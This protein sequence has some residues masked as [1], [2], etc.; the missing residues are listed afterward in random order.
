MGKSWL[1]LWPC[2]IVMLVCQR[3]SELTFWLYNIAMENDPFMDDDDKH[4]DLPFLR[5]VIFHSYVKD[6]RVFFPGEVNIDVE[7]SIVSLGTCSTCM[8]GFP[9]LYLVGGLEHFLFF[10]ILRTIIPTDELIFFRGVGQPPT[11]SLLEGHKCNDL[12]VTSTVVSRASQLLANVGLPHEL[13]RGRSC[14]FGCDRTCFCWINLF[15][16]LLNLIILSSD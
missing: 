11:I 14:S 12:R 13:Y 3:V 9:H 7:N 1:F 10:H 2:S 15:I 16:D 6:Q 4:D 8:V 5:M